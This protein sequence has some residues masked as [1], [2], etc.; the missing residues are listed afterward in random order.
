LAELHDA[1]RLEPLHLVPPARVQ[2][3]VAESKELAQV[4]PL[5]LFVF[6]HLVFR[7]RHFFLEFFLF[8]LDFLVPVFV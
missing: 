3:P 1:Q 2:K 5:L 8:V 4:T 7:D 6:A